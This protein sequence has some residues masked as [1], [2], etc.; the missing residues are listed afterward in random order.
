MPRSFRLPGLLAALVMSTAN[1]AGPLLLEAA[2]VKAL[3]IETAVAGEVG[4]LRQGAYPA[5]VLVPNEQMRIVSAPVA[6]MVEMLAVAPGAAVKRGQVVAQLASQQALE[7]QRDALQAGS[8]AALLQQ[9]LKRDEQLFAEGLIAESRLQNTRASA[10]QASAQASERRQG[11]SLAGVAPGKLGGPLA[12]TATIDGVVLEQ[13]VQLGQRVEASAM[14]YRIARLSPLWLEIQAPLDFARGLKEGNVVRVAGSDV[15][16]RLIVIGRAVDAASQ[17]V[18]L[19]ATVSQGAETLHPGQVV[20]V[21]I[22]G[23]PGRGQRLPAGALARNAGKTVVFVQTA[24]SNTG[25][26]FMPK[27][28]SVLS[29]GGDS[30]VVDG[31]QAGERVAV[32]G[33]SGLKALLAGVGSE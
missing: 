11:L 29:Q 2:Q 10:M 14:I 17:T 32:T 15:S 7:L 25:L 1:A 5:R 22:T 21:D 3:G 19:R 6:G 26:T 9:S 23:P 12:L 18:L 33:V 16:G 24:A 8:Q 13:G 20:E 31:I 28:V 27:P 4:K 30:V